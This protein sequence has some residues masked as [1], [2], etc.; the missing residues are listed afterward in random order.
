MEK[1][2]LHA[3]LVGM[4]VGKATVENSMKVLQEI[5]NENTIIS[6]NSTSGYL[7]IENENANSERYMQLCAYCNIIYSGNIQKQSKCPLTDE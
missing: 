5:K 3:Q 6:S 2:R 4:Q 7:P 1:R